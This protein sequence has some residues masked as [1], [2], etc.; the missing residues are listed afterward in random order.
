MP[1]ELD[2]N[3]LALK[4]YPFQWGID[5]TFGDM[6]IVGHVNNVALARYYETGRSRFLI[7]MTGNPSFFTSSKI[8]TVVAEYTVRFLGEINFPDQVTVGTAIGRIGNSSFSSLQALFV[9]GECVGL[10]D[11]AMVL[12]CDS[13]PWKIDDEMRQKMQPFLMLESV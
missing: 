2:P 12:T 6:D 4:N 9:N 13:K 3:R 7:E 1:R 5:T 10:S 11:A 8:N